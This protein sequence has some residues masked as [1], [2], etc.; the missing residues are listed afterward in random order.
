MQ[1]DFVSA[2][3]IFLVSVYL[4]IVSV[5]F[6]AGRVMVRIY[7]SEH[8]LAIDAQQRA[9]MAETYLA[10]VHEEAANEKDRSI[11][12]AALFRA[13]NDGIIKD[14]SAPTFSILGIISG[15]QTS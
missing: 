12:L 14:D 5:F 9:T 4:L 1:L 10:L 15:A 13:T 2:Q 8:H 7:L 3:A 6:W 11:V